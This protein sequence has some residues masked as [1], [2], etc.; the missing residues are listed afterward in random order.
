MTR[1]SSA[2]AAVLLSLFCVMGSPALADN[3]PAEHHMVGVGFHDN[4]APLGVRW[5][6]GSQ[7]V[8]V[9]LVFTC[10]A[11]PRVGCCPGVCHGGA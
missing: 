11:R 2:V 9:D 6:L 7:K 5:W 1:R 10:S 3:G 8:A 4:T